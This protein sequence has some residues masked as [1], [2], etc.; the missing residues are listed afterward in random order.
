MPWAPGPASALCT[1]G[2]EQACVEGRHGLGAVL[3]DGQGPGLEDSSSSGRGKEEKKS[4]QVRVVAEKSVGTGVGCE[5]DGG[6]CLQ[7]HRHRSAA[8][9]PGVREKL[10]IPSARRRIRSEAPGHGAGVCS[11]S[12]WLPS[13]GSLGQEDGQSG[14][15]EQSQE[16]APSFPSCMAL[17][18]WDVALA[19]AGPGAGHQPL[20]TNE[21]GS[22]AGQV[23]VGR[24]PCRGA[25]APLLHLPQLGSVFPESR[26]SWVWAP[27]TSHRLSGARVP[28]ADSGLCQAG[29]E[30]L[31][32]MRGPLFPSVCVK[33]GIDF[34]PLRQPPR[35]V[36][37]G[38]PLA[39]AGLRSAFGGWGIS[40]GL[41]FAP[42]SIP[43]LHLSM[44]SHQT[45]VA[46]PW[47]NIC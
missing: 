14:A 15:G 6:R 38:Q 10:I 39:G 17:L 31:E 2:G 32:G 12:V 33:M 40:L 19:V 5:R 25:L 7:Y 47:L 8:S 16:A 24:S 1:V 3:T 9:V 23:W 28:T 11:V 35:G 41:H 30:G 29:R 46:E 22:G 13:Q 20:E 34:L 44:L 36:R 37:E 18:A 26:H 45:W 42:P 27:R 43:L 21:S 4:T